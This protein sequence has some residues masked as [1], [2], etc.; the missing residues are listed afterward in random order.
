MRLSDPAVREKT[1]LPASE[2]AQMERLVAG[3]KG[4][5]TELDNVR[6]RLRQQHDQKRSQQSNAL[7]SAPNLASF[8]EHGRV[9][10]NVT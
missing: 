5:H 3:E 2:K 4:Y 9:N 6:E 7:W 1:R 10:E 8:S